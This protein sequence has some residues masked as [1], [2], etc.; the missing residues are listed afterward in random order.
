MSAI[1]LADEL[2][3]HLSEMELDQVNLVSTNSVSNSSQQTTE[4]FP[5]GLLAFDSNDSQFYP[6]LLPGPV[7]REGLPNS[8]RFWKDR[9]EDPRHSNPVNLIYGPSGCGKSSLVNA[10]IL[11]RLSNQILV[12]KIEATVDDTEVRLLKA[13]RDLAP[14]LSDEINLHELIAEIREGKHIPVNKR[15]LIVFDQFEQWLHGNIFEDHCQLIGALRQCDGE[16]VQALILVREDFWLGITRFFKEL[17]I[18]LI[19]NINFASVDLFSRRHA[20]EVLIKFGRAYGQLPSDTALTKSNHRFLDGAVEMMS[21]NGT[22][23]SI[24]TAL[25]AETVKH[26]DWEI[27]TLNQLGD[28]KRIG[29]VF[30]DKTIGD[31]AS[32]PLYI[33]NRENLI[34]I[35]ETLLPDAGI[36]IKGSFQPKQKLAESVALTNS[37]PDFQIL[38]QILDK[39][40]RLITP[41]EPDHGIQAQSENDKYYQLTHDYLVPSL[42][43]WI[44][45][46]R[47]KTKKGRAKQQLRQQSLQWHVTKEDRYLPTLSELC[48]MQLHVPRSLRTSGE[49]DFLSKA[50]KYYG[51]W[52]GG[53]FL[54]IIAI[55]LSFWYVNANNMESV[56]NGGMTSRSEDLIKTVDAIAQPS[57]AADILR[58]KYDS[59]DITD[60]IRILLMLGL[61]NELSDNE[62]EKL[63]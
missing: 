23:N 25:F 21:E 32:N 35:L 5:K 6:E 63:I 26:N 45:E 37:D 33:K 58:S 43:D 61:L 10:G 18:D 40:L 31:R 54:S 42:R 39:Q 15:L 52:I 55:F 44:F 53:M 4:F 12:A 20:K 24:R 28:A 19:E 30:L 46:Y 11:P 48:G 36:E 17:E 51:K 9:I 57:F 2:E 56:V 13:I 62:L 27:D 14:E 22:V 38:I 29:V 1:D 50:G 8:I 49:N 59:S 41:T 16:R 47:G 60:K 34:T 7:D 3:L